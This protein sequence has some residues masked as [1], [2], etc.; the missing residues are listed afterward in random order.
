MH[1][2]WMSE[3]NELGKFLRV[4]R[5]SL[6]PED[7]GLRSYGSR[8]VPGLRREELAMVAGVSITYYTRLE[9][10][11]SNN[12]SE[13]VIEAIAGALNLNNVERGHLMDLARPVKPKRSPASKPDFARAGTIRLIRSMIATPTVVLGRRS[14]VLAWNRLGHRLV[15]G[16]LDFDGPNQPSTR[17]NMTRMLFLDPHTRK[18]YTRWDEEIVRAVSSLRLLAGRNADDPELAAFVG[19]LS[20]K[21][22]CFAQLWA[23]HPVE[24]CMSGLKYMHHP[25]VG[26]LEL[27]FEVLT[28]PDDSGHRVLMYTADPDSPSAEA[29]RQLGSEMPQDVAGDPAKKPAVSSRA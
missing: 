27:N 26:T 13:S 10:G 5:A 6:R 17:A 1:N 2:G 24:N 9:Q 25:E 7:V 21:S 22:L 4:R 8:R 20:V 19:E 3:P 14:E 28:P 16:H 23:Q 11:L 29:L 12:A 15:A 18:L